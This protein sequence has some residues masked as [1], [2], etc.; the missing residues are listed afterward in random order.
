MLANS[1]KV[2]LKEIS[3]LFLD[4]DGVINHD[5]GYVH[6][7]R[8][9]NLCEGIVDFIKYFNKYDIPVVIVTNQAGIGRG[10]YDLSTYIAFQDWVEDYLRS[11]NCFIKKTYFC[12]Y[13][14]DASIEKYKKDSWFRKPSPGMLYQ[15]KFE[16]GINLPKSVLI[17]DK[18]SD[19]EAARRAGIRSRFLFRPTESLK[20]TG[21]E[22]VKILYRF[23]DFFN[24]TS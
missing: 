5:F 10:L 18:L 21:H 3:C 2:V 19:V 15:A 22:H 8:D 24:Y 17:G 23:S 14:R 7:V 13:H 20:N 16:L 4:R 12:P 9:F 1:N 11:K 6:R